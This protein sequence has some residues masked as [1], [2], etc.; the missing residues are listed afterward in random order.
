VTKT[1]EEMNAQYPLPVDKRRLQ[2][3]IDGAT[4][5]QG[6]KTTLDSAIKSGIDWYFWGEIMED[7]SGIRI[8]HH[9]SLDGERDSS[10][11]LKG[12]TEEEAYAIMHTHILLGVPLE[13][14]EK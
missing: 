6:K 10:R 14:D 9:A 1:L 4:T 5:T 2:W 11:T 8:H 3:V 7:G 13:S 12:A